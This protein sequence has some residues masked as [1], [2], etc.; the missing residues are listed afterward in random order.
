MSSTS[1]ASGPDISM[2]S[3]STNAMRCGRS[4]HCKHGQTA[5]YLHFVDEHRLLGVGGAGRDLA[6]REI[7]GKGVEREVLAL[8]RA[9]LE[10]QDVVD[11][12]PIDPRLEPAPKS[13]LRQ[14]C[15]D[16]D[17]D[18]LR[19]IFGVFLVPQLAQ[20]ETVDVP[21]S[22]R[23]SVSRASRSPLSAWRANSSRTLGVV[24]VSLRISL[25]LRAFDDAGGRGVKAALPAFT[26]ADVFSSN[27]RT[28]HG[29][30]ISMRTSWR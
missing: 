17:Q 13:E 7:L 19:G 26:L 22:A 14:A 12:Q 28:A 29:T 10:I 5:P 30:R 9:L 16:T 3:P 18:L 15:H 1:A 11:R 8:D 25:G 6:C 24:T 23:T 20:R 2:M 21:C 27:E 4:R